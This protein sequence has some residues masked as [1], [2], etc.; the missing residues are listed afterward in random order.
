MK[1]F[2]ER[3]EDLKNAANKLEEALH[4]EVS[5]L[6]I[7]GIFIFEIKKLIKKLDTI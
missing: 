1:R 7:D 5:E 2:E 3:K 6:E 4:K